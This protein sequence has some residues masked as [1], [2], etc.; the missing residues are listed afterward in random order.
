MGDGP[1]VTIVTPSYNMAGSLTETL[2]SVLKQDYPAIEYIVVDGGSTDGTLEI[3]QRYANSLRYSSGPDNCPAD[4]VHKGLA[5][6]RGEILAWLNADDMYRPGAV[7]RAV[8]YL[9][10]HPEVD[11]VYGDGWWIDERGQRIRLYPSMPFD[12]RV[13]E[14][15]CFICQPA[16]FL[17]ASAYRGCP[18]DPTLKASFDYDLWIRMA[19][20]G[21]RFAYLPEHLADSRMHRGSQTLYARDLVFRSSMALL[22]RHYGYIPF[23]WVFGYAAFR[24]DGRDQFFEPLQPSAVKYLV[25]LPLGVWYNRSHPFRYLREWVAAPWKGMSRRL[26]K[27][28]AR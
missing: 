5:Q 14:R 17:R 24:M 1:L 18:I 28:S 20:A 9:T 19:A 11:I 10:V 15:D 22:R 16:A 7:R 21:L 26:R 27:V 25:S 6:A 13:L 8:E 4:A 2:D 3:L 12:P 23:S